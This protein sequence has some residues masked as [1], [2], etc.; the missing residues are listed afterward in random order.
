LDPDTTGSRARRLF[1]GGLY[2]AESVLKTVAERHGI[3][4]DLIP[5]IA[6]GFCSGQARTG[7]QCGAVSGAIMAI[8]MVTGR[9]SHE[10]SVDGTYEAVGEFLREFR[11]RFGSTNC[12]GLLGCDIGTQEG[13]DRFE[14]EGLE[15]RCS[16]F[17]EIAA[18]IAARVLD[19]HSK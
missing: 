4:S 8:S 19:K 13:R 17:T 14:A 12:E 7:G 1:E 3:E 5:S 18:V 16:D 6:T 15:K 11:G 2:C 10:D 9:R